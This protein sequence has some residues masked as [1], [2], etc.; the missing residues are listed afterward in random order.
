MDIENI[1]SGSNL[2]VMLSADA[3]HLSGGNTFVFLNSLRSHGLLE[4]LRRYAADGGVII[5]VSAGAI[6]LTPDILSSRLCGDTQPADIVNTAALGLIDFT[7][8]PHLGRYASIAD[9]QIHSRQTSQLVIACADGAAIVVV[10]DS[11]ECIGEV[12]R[13]D[14]GI[15][16]SGPGPTSRST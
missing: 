1:R 3:N 10:N 2:D 11:L 9:L 7:F 4:P 15:V 12:V 16:C 13:I 6:I 14:K 5:G 8:V